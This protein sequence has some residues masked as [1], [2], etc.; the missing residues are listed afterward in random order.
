MKAR[1]QTPFDSVRLQ[2]LLDAAPIDTQ[3]DT[4]FASEYLAFYGLDDLA[5]AHRMW[6]VGSA[7]SSAQRIVAQAFVPESPQ[8]TAF[9]CHGYYDHVGLY[10]HLLEYLLARNITVVTF[11]QLGHGLSSGDPVN[12]ASFDEY[13]LATELV[14]SSALR[15]GVIQQPPQHLLGQSMGGAVLLEY[16][17]Q[18]AIDRVDGELVLFAPLVRPYAWAINRWI[19]ALAK[20]TVTERARTLGNNA[21][22][23]DFQALQRKDPLQAHVLPVRWVQAMI[24]WFKRFERY[25]AS[26]LAP[27]IVQGYADRTVSWR[28]NLKIMRRRYPEGALLVLPAARHHLVNE[29]PAL[30]QRMWDWFDRECVWRA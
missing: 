25:P 18:S 26:L 19:F 28:H 10:G 8:S 7:Q 27:K 13:V 15:I 23:S 24:D 12:I 11:D 22:N 6:V 4:Q 17:Q 21:E 2:Q 5:H 16:F 29:S 30:R 9:L 3:L 1:G 14:L 20:L